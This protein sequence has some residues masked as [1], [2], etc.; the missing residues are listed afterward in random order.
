MPV[1]L[2]FGSTSVAFQAEPPKNEKESKKRAEALD[3]FVE[4]VLSV[5][6]ECDVDTGSE[7]LRVPHACDYR[8]GTLEVCQ[9]D[10]DMYGASRVFSNLD[11]MSQVPDPLPLRVAQR[12]VLII[13]AQLA[14]L[15]GPEEQPGMPTYFPRVVKLVLANAYGTVLAYHVDMEDPGI[16]PEGYEQAQLG[17]R[18]E[19]RYMRSSILEYIGKNGVIGGLQRDMGAHR[20]AARP[21][22][23]ARH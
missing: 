18:K 21:R 15:Q 2:E 11:D 23:N 6:G 1:L 9:T 17:I 3:K 19:W 20:S 16:Y 22:R 7:P 13:C 8:D 10:L 14:L 12:N 5:A 4:V